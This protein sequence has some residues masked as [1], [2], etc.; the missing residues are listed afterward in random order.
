MQYICISDKM[1][2]GNEKERRLKLQRDAMKKI[3]TLSS[4]RRGS[5]FIKEELPRVSKGTLN[6]LVKKGVLMRVESPF[7]ELGFIYY[8]WTGKEIE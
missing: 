3:N 1:L 8:S 5:L 4:A 7:K 2:S 6:A